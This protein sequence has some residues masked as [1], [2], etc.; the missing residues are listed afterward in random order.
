MI[1]FS[2]FSLVQQLE[3]K[4]LRI[5]K[6]D[7]Y[8]LKFF[9][10]NSIKKKTVLGTVILKKKKKLNFFRINFFFRKTDF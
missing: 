7:L 4:N 9:T 6:N 1:I 10:K 8:L 3:K 2:M 5:T